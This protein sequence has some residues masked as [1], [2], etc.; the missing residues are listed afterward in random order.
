MKRKLLGGSLVPT[1][2]EAEGEHRAASPSA[3]KGE[4]AVLSYLLLAA[5]HL[6]FGIFNNYK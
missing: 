4:P 2:G 5:E 1:I 6:N 3:E